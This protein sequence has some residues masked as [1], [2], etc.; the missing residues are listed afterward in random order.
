MPLPADLQPFVTDD[1]KADPVAWPILEKVT[2]KD[3]PAVLKS[4][5]HSQHRL[6]SAI[7]LP[8]GPADVETWR[9]EHLP[10]L[11]AAGVLTPP[12][13][14]PDEYAITKPEDLPEGLGWND[15][16]SKELAATLHKHAIPKAAVADLLALHTKALA[17]IGSMTE[18]EA[19]A[20][21]TDGLAALKAEF[22]DKF[23]ELQ[24]GA[25]RLVS[26]LF[27]TPEELD[28]FEKVRIGKHRLAD[29]PRF[30]G[31][32]MRLAPL[33]QQDSSFIRD[34]SRPGGGMDGDAVRL[35]VSKI[36]NDKTHPMYEGYWRKDPA[37]MQHIDQ[38]YRKAYGEEKVVLGG[39]TT[40]GRPG[41]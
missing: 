12:P 4:Y 9:K 3:V 13:A 11:Y 41:A 27:K 7:G 23:E 14:S 38:L 2:E 15:E 1:L 10:K 26:S 20:S 5:A 17:G 40:E 31:P 21:Y 8:K 37:V 22:G 18:A 30:L 34:L 33:A 36:M 19:A 32:M 28:L 35:E 39:V 25:K 29:D 16:L 24:E 6:G